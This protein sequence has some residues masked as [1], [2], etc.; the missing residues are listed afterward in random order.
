MITVWPPASIG[1]S[2]DAVTGWWPSTEDTG[3]QTV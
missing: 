1:S 2:P 3:D